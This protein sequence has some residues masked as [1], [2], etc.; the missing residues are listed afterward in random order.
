MTTKKLTSLKEAREYLG[1]SL[2][3]VATATG[4]APA[5]IKNLESEIKDCGYK[6][7]TKLCAFYNYHLAHKPYKRT[8]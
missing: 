7:Y 4:M 2:R 5:T 3:F 8:Q 1:Y 6:K